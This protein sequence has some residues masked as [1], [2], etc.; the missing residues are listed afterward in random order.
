MTTSGR[1]TVHVRDL[2]PH[3]IPAVVTL[4]ARGMRDNPLPVAAFGEDPERRQRCVQALFGALFRAF[5]RA[6]VAKG[7]DHDDADRTCKGA[8]GDV[9]EPEDGVVGI[10]DERL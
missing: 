7:L 6:Q 2:R 5:R 1:S 3:E 10:G 8:T 9:V 4:L